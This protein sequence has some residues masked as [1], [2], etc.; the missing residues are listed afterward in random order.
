MLFD[1][2]ASIETFFPVF[3]SAGLFCIGLAGVLIR[4]N[5]LVVLM[6]LELMLNAVNLNLLAF[7]KLYDLKEGPV[8]IFLI[9]C[10]AAGEAGIGLALAVR[11]YNKFKNINISDLKTLKG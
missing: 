8:F 4:K 11:V 7:S 2:L 6:S 5:I 1:S 9:I 10:V 3:L